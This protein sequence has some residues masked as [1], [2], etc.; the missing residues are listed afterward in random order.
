M[1]NETEVIIHS[2]AQNDEKR[3]LDLKFLKISLIK[4]NSFGFKT[5]KFLFNKIKKLLF[6]VFYLILIR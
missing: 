6:Y 4:N 1:G 5:I 3:N 2:W